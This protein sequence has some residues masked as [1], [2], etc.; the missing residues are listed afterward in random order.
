MK[1]FRKPLSLVMAT[2]M[3]ANVALARYVSLHQTTQVEILKTMPGSSQLTILYTGIL[4]E[5][6]PFVDFYKRIRGDVIAPHCG[7]LD[8]RADHLAY[9]PNLETWLEGKYEINVIGISM[10]AVAAAKA[11]KFLQTSFADR[12]IQLFL[13]D[14]CMGS[15][16]IQLVELPGTVMRGLSSAITLA[17]YALGGLSFIPVAR[18]HSLANIQGEIATSVQKVEPFNE[19]LLPMTKVV[20]SNQDWLVDSAQVAAYFQDCAEIDVIEASHADFIADHDA[21]LAVLK[22]QGLFN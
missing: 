21:W 22:K 12:Q 17:S 13:L 1:G 11:A 14:P 3:I 15:D 5:T 19:Q 4:G 18:G 20:I 6:A 8:Y 16:Q 2:A 9:P 10:G 7:K